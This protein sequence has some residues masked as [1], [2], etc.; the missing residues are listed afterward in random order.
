MSDS[1][2]WEIVLVRSWRKIALTFAAALALASVA[3][4]ATH[5]AFIYD[6]ILHAD[7]V[8]GDAA[9]ARFALL[10]LAGIAAAVAALLSARV[11][12]KTRAGRVDWPLHREILLTSLMALPLLTAPS[13]EFDHALFTAVLIVAL[14]L[15]LAHAVARELEPMSTP[16]S[17]LPTLTERQALGLV[18]LGYVVFV[19][20]IGFLAYWRF[21]TFH[22]E[23]CDASWEIG[24]I[25]GM[26]RHGIPTNSIGA[27]MYDGKPLPAPYFNNHVPLVEYLFVPFYAVVRNL[28]VLFWLQAAFMGSG[29]FGSYLIGR[30]WLGGRGAG[31]LAAALYL[32]NPSVQ[33]FCLHDIH[34]NVLIIPAIV[35]AVGFMEAERPRLACA[36]ALLAALSREEAPLYAAGL[37]L[38]WMFSG[39]GRQ[40][41]RRRFRIGL[42]LLVTSLALEAFFVGF[43][44]PHFGGQPRQDHFNLYFDGN[45]NLASLL[46]ALVLDPLGAAFASTT[47]AK[48]D[49]AAISLVWMGGLALLGW[50]AAWLAL[51]AL[52][53]QI[54]AGDVGFF[55]LGMNYSAPIVP[56]MVLMGLAALRRL[57]TRSGAT[58]ASRAGLVAYV[59]TTALLANYLYGN[60]ASKTY[61]FEYGQSPYRRQNQRNWHDAVA[62]ID[63]LPPFGEAEKALWQ[64]VRH[65]PYDG[66]IL[67]SW[68]VN[69][70]LSDHD[71]ALAYGFSGGHPPAEERVRYIV[72]DKLPAMMTATEGDLRRLRA[73]PRWGV[74]YE[75]ASGVI[76]ERR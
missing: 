56:A 52:L 63:A 26:L 10:P 23:V 62:Y 40:E 1:V 4:Q 5:P 54:P 61:K 57:W 69:P 76:F 11:L 3:W 43:L 35:L 31:V 9:R 8:S 74:R 22:A 7:A 44:M 25:A 66:P 20:V 24:S 75:N 39:P 71:V 42:A 64:V 59:L 37:A 68:I 58:F 33:C 14:G 28:R 70:Q 32:L 41:D 50:R 34:A 46:G 48:L 12:Q 18:T 67:T 27:W 29:A 21:I 30:R 51:P 60:I 15:A 49:Y 36:F 53:L 16:G 55:T 17:S 38:F 2:A 47:E 13:V 73:D 65:V 19:A 6:F 45:R 72:I